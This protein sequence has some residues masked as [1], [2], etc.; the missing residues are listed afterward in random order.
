MYSNMKSVPKRSDHR[1]AD[2]FQ[3]G[4]GSETDSSPSRL[5]MATF[6]SGLLLL[7][8]ACSTGSTP[9]D[10]EPAAVAGS[11]SIIDLVKRDIKRGDE[12]TVTEKNG[13]VHRLKVSKVDDEGIHGRDSRRKRVS[14]PFDDFHSLA[15]QRGVIRESNDTRGGSEHGDWAETA[16]KAIVIGGLG[17]LL[18]HEVVHGIGESAADAL[19]DGLVP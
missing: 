13:A 2:W 4:V 15:V 12:V 8:P 3:S 17:Y 18:F 7:V 19:A 6:L 10:H 1:G 11:P 14:I 5:A 9:K 16:G